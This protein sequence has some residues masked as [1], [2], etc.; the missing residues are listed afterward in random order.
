MCRVIERKTGKRIY[1]LFDLIVGTSTGSVIA[2]GLGVL[3]LRVDE[4]E[5]AYDTLTKAFKTSGKD[6]GW[7]EQLSGLVTAG[8]QNIRAIFR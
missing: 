8:T 6:A 5:E 1:E 4:V 3:G 7:T 2:V